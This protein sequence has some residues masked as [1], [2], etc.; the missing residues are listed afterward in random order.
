MRY[1]Y[2]CLLLYLTLLI[3]PIHAQQAEP[4][5]VPITSDNINE[6]S[7]VGALPRVDGNIF[8]IEWSPTSPHL[9]ALATHAGVQ[10]YHVDHAMA[11]LWV[12]LELTND[13]AVRLGWSPDGKLIIHG[14]SLGGGLWLWDADSGRQLATLA[15]L[16]GEGQ[17]DRVAFDPTGTLIANFSLSSPTVQVWGIED[18]AEE[19]SVIAAENAFWLG[20]IAQLEHPD[21]MRDMIFSPDGEL[22]ATSNNDGVVR[23][24]ET[25]TFSVVDEYPLDYTDGLAFSPD[26]ARLAV[27]SNDP[28]QATVI[29]IAEGSTMTITPEATV[30][31]PRHL[32][33]TPDGSFL[34]V[35]GGEFGDEGDQPIRFMD[36]QPDSETFGEQITEIPAAHPFTIWEIG[37]NT[38]D[39]TLA[40]LGWS[41]NLQLWQLGEPLDAILTTARDLEVNSMAMV[42]LAFNDDQLNVRAGAG[43]DNDIVARLDAGTLVTIIGGPQTVGELRW[44]QVEL[45]DGTTGWTVDGVEGEVTLRPAPG[46]P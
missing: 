30:N 18:G 14:V 38:T 5:P 35:F 39:T 46:R 7:N 27:I 20:R 41:D 10:I 42:T 1:L 21:E 11:E 12:T 31:G 32:A 16:R 15:G 36:V 2:L 8:D 19:R 37:F 23:L 43:T 34:A 44:W 6:V 26:G 25:E 24:W 22:L 4:D 3:I 17:N 9:L 29:D 28:M 13:L 40:S 45:A 33:F